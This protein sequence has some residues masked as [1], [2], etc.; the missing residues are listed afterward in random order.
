MANLGQLVYQL[1]K[2]GIGSNLST[3]HS[4]SRQ[5]KGASNRYGRAPSLVSQYHGEGVGNFAA[6]PMQNAASGGNVDLAPPPTPTP[7][8][9]SPSPTPSPPVSAGADPGEGQSTDNSILG[10]MMSNAM[11]ANM[12]GKG[13]KGLGQLGLKGLAMNAP[14]GMMM[15]AAPQVAIQS[16]LSMPSVI[17]NA[18]AIA[19]SGQAAHS[20]AQ[21]TALDPSEID[22]MASGLFSQMPTSSPLSALMNLLSDNPFGDLGSNA[23]GGLNISPTTP[24]DL[25]VSGQIASPFADMS[26][27]S[28]PNAQ[29]TQT[30]QEAAT[31]LGTLFGMEQGKGFST[32]TPAGT[33]SSLDHSAANTNTDST[34]NFNDTSP[35]RG[36]GTS[37][38]GVTG[39]SGNMGMGSDAASL[40]AAEAASSASSNSGSSPTGPMGE[41]PD[42]GGDGG[43]GCTVICTELHRQGLISDDIY[44]ADA[45]FGKSL[46][47]DTIRGYHLWGKPVARAMRKSPLLTWLIKP[48]VLSW[49]RAMAGRQ[50]SLFWSVALK[51]GIPV[52]R[53][54]GR[55]N[56]NTELIYE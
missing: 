22:P 15:E 6:A 10:T 44:K 52:C 47:D 55:R 5:K 42:A 27:E 40:A 21:N 24:A 20:Q 17:S 11:A 31:Q 8:P 2:Q 4:L 39:T 41:G 25:D 37:A 28:D 48:I 56:T 14:W 19:A 54:I 12:G 32:P 16:M 46:D 3:L 51:L 50:N 1:P 38:Q 23:L 9:F 33:I 30:S 26:L 18:T 45:A 29:S 35:A 43:D 7:A 13:L 53:F 34:G 36:A 49:A